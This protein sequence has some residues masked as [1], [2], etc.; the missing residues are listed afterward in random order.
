[1]GCF[2]VPLSTLAFATLAPKYRNEASAL[3]S[4]A[5]NIGSSIG[6][7]IAVTLLVRNIQV[8]HATLSEHVTP[9]NSL[10]RLPGASR[11]WDLG[12]TAGLLT[13]NQEVTRQAASIAYVNDFL[14]MM[15]LSLATIPILLLLK[16]PRRV[17]ATSS[18]A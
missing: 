7:S 16:N 10:L 4:L 13:L 9:F 12:D 1:M 3:F 5:R 15:Y 6:I 11:F 14:I 17:P 8:N 2:F 18:I